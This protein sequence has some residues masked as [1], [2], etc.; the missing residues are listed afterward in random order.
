MAAADDR[1]SAAVFS[2]PSSSGFHRLSTAKVRRNGF[3]AATA[4]PN[5]VSVVS[6]ASVHLGGKAS[7][8]GFGK[9]VVAAF[10][11]DVAEFLRLTIVNLQPSALFG[12]NRLFRSPDDLSVN[13]GVFREFV[14]RAPSVERK[15]RATRGE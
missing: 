12:S 11:F 2:Q 5:G 15:R 6:S 7:G 4:R 1:R 14:V 3:S 9:R 13:F 10:E 8:D